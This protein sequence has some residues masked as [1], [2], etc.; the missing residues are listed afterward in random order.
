MNSLYI[1]TQAAGHC[2][3][4]LKL[5]LSRLTLDGLYIRELKKFAE[6]SNWKEQVCIKS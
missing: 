1:Y 6:F 5:F 4:R 2:S 3:G